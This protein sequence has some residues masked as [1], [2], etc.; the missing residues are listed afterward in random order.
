MYLEG[1]GCLQ[2]I[3]GLARGEFFFFCCSPILVGFFFFGLHDFCLSYIKKNDFC[4]ISYQF[5]VD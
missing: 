1:K 2:C 4:K 5:I 3:H